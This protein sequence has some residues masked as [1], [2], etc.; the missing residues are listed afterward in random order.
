MGYRPA[1]K[2]R[3][4]WEKKSY[5]DV[6]KTNKTNNNNSKK[7]AEKKATAK[8]KALGVG[9]QSQLDCSIW[10]VVWSHECVFSVNLRATRCV[11][12][13]EKELHYKRMENIINVPHAY[14]IETDKS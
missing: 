6:S 8:K 5:F 4:N 11:D 2:L 12:G 13:D 9:K 10:S 1:Y 7:K 3:W 14:R